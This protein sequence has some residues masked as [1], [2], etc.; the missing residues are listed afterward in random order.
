MGL[1][2]PSAAIAKGKITSIELDAARAPRKARRRNG[3][4]G[5]QDK[6]E[7]LA[8]FAGRFTDHDRARHVGFDLAAHGVGHGSVAV[9]FEAVPQAPSGKKRRCTSSGN[10]SPPWKEVRCARSSTC[11]K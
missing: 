3:N 10:C 11:Q 7:A 9:V 2:A 8:H 5:L 6:R 1:A 4:M